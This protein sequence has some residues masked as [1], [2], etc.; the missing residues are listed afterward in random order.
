MQ[1]VYKRQKS[2]INFGS[3]TSGMGKQVSIMVGNLAN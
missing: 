3:Y 2:D 1:L